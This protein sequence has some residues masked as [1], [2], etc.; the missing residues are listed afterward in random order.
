MYISR[1]V[2]LLCFSG[3]VIDSACDHGGVSRKWERVPV[4]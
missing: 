2:A 1:G 4:G 3:V